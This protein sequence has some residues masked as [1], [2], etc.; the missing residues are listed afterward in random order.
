MEKS[1]EATQQ[2]GSHSDAWHWVRYS[3]IIA[4]VPILFNVFITVGKKPFS[5]ADFLYNGELLYISF[6]LSGERVGDLY[7]NN[8][9]MEKTF[10]ACICTLIGS[11]LGFAGISQIDK[12]FF[13]YF[14]IAIFVLTVFAGISSKWE[15]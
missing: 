1:G 8:R 14:S 12:T 6:A 4:I 3:L 2:K 10:Y 15:N 9:N 11:A 5:L 13:M 7:R